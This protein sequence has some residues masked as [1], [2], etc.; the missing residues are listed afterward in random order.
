[1]DE[2]IHNSSHETPMDRRAGEKNLLKKKALK[3]TIQEHRRR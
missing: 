3:Y 2:C 1:M